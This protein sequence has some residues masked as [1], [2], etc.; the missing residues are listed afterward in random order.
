MYYVLP[1]ILSDT[2]STPSQTKA[3][4]RESKIPIH[5]TRKEEKA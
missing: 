3:Q 2:N 5:F 1:H 4:Q